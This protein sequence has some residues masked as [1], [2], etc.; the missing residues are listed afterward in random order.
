ML[1]WATTDKWGWRTLV[2]PSPTRPVSSLGRRLACRRGRGGRGQDGHRSP[3][4]G[5]AGHS[6]GRNLKGRIDVGPG[7]DGP[8]SMIAPGP[9]RWPTS[10]PSRRSSTGIRTTCRIHVE[11]RGGVRSRRRPTGSG[12]CRWTLPGP[13]PR[14]P[15]AGGWV[16]AW[17][18]KLLAIPTA[19]TA[20]EPN[21]IDPVSSPVI[22]AIPEAL[23]AIPSAPLKLVDR[24]GGRRSGSPTRRGPR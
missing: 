14:E 23:T 12:R 6:E 22:E 1:A 24:P 15:K 11:Y 13:G 10:T 5:R 2:M 8:R 16:V 17:A 21:A 18:T 19:G 20:V 4:T 7:G 3:R 9:V